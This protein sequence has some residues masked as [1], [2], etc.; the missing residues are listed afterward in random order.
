MRRGEYMC[1]SRMPMP[2]RAAAA[3]TSAGAIPGRLK[4]TVGE[5]GNQG[6]AHVEKADDGG[7]EQVFQHSAHGEVSSLYSF[8]QSSVISRS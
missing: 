8:N 5:P 4:Q 2:A 1:P 7:T 6:R 3:V